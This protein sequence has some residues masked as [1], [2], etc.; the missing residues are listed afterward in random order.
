M[1]F[2]TFEHKSDIGIRGIG[3]TKEKSFEEAARC[4]FN[5]QVDIKK[6][7]LSKKIIINARA[8]N[9][10]ELFVEFLNKLISTSAI[11]Q[12]VFRK[13]IVKIRENKSKKQ[14][15]L[16]AEA[17]GEKLNLKKHNVDVEVK[18][19][20]YGELK[21]YQDNENLEK[22]SGCQKSKKISKHKKTKNWISQCI[23]DV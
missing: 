21:V 7:K 14:F 16:K 1:T 23:V 10:E 6:I 18:A 13:F 19:A 2:K 17:F 3:K 15:E 20:T 22:F 11:K 4:L 5:V 8:E 9:I 12:M